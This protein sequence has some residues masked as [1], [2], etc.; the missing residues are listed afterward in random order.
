MEDLPGGLF[1]LDI[2]LEGDS[3]QTEEILLSY[4][5]LLSNKRITDKNASLCL[6]ILGTNSRKASDILF[7]DR[8]PETFFT[9]V[10]SAGPFIEPVFNLLASFY[11]GKLYEKILLACTGF[12]KESYASNK[13]ITRVYLPTDENILHT[14]KYLVTCRKK[15]AD[16]IIGFLNAINNSDPCPESLTSLLPEIIS[17]YFDTAKKIDSIFPASLIGGADNGISHTKGTDTQT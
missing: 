6:R 16:C 12:L 14:A 15:T 11:P 17:S 13:Y 8:N 9:A 7:G 4:A 5:V 10:H 1:N 3:A 2:I